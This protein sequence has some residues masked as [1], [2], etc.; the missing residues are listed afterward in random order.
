MVS[1]DSLL[2]REYD[3][4]LYNCRHFAGEAWELLTGD[5]RLRQV[6]ENDLNPGATAALFRGFRRVAGPTD[7]PSIALMENLTGDA[8]IGVCYRRRL[9]HLPSQGPQFILMDAVTPLYRNLRF[10]A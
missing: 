10:W 3:E 9:L 1:I 5:R 8:H 2:D 7:Q 6:N 4:D